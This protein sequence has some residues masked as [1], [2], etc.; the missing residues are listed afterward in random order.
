MHVATS[1]NATPIGGR[2]TSRRRTPLWQRSLRALW[3]GAGAAALYGCSAPNPDLGAL[4]AEEIDYNW[5]VRPI[6]SDRCFLCHGPDAEAR[7][8]ELR[9]DTLRGGH[10]RPTPG[11]DRAR[12]TGGSLLSQGLAPTTGRTHAAGGAARR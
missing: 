6:L 12:R 2:A 5:H 1:I 10:R 4:T 7:Q 11:R 3:F 9:L 8:A